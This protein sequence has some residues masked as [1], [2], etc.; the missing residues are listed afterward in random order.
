MVVAALF[1][2]MLLGAAIYAPFARRDDAPLRLLYNE[3]RAS[4]YRKLF[5]F[6]VLAAVAPVLLFAAAFGAYMTDKFRL[7]VEAEASSVVR[8]ARRV[9]EE[10]AAA[11]AGRAH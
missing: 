10:L 2:L 8:V 5:L 7:D 9:F 3:I 6:F 11:V 1:V 4:F